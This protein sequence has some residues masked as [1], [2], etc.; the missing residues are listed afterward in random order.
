MQAKMEAASIIENNN[1][2]AP[3]ILNPIF[4]PKDDG[5][6]HITVDMKEANK[7]ILSTNIPMFKATDIH[8]CLSSCKYFDKLDFK[9]TSHQTEI[10]EESQHITAF[11]A[12]D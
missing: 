11:H 9:S 10:T 5:G 12:R 8:A 2:P 4:A 3:W 6:M 7:A 1:G